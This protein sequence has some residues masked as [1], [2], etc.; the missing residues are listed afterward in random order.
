MKGDDLTPEN[1]YKK[2]PKRKKSLAGGGTID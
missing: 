2:S 1:Y